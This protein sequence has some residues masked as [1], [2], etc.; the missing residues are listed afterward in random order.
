LAGV[1]D[2][3]TLTLCP[4]AN[5]DAVD[6]KFVT[7]DFEPVPIKLDEVEVKLEYPKPVGPVNPVGP[8]G[9]ETVDAVPEG[10]VGPVGPVN[11][12]GPVA[13]LTPASV[14]VQEDA[15]VVPRL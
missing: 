7:N 12:V 4:T 1:A 9:P 13:P 11:P 2:E 5:A 14:T 6:A 3:A 8:V 10:P 15:A